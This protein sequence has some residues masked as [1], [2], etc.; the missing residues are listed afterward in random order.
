MAIPA[1]PEILTSNPDPLV[2]ALTWVVGVEAVALI[3][4]LGAGIKTVRW[5]IERCDNRNDSAWGKVA[6]LTS[7]VNQANT[8]EQARQHRVQT[9]NGVAG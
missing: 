5:L 9:Q 8:L 6:G 4:V 1:A 2:Q 3:F 7:A